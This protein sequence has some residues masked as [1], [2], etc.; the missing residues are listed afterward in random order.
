M[1]LKQEITQYVNAGDYQ[2]ILFCAQQSLAKTLRYVQM[3]IWGDDHFLPRW[4]AIEALGQLAAHFAGDNDEDFRNLIRRC[5][6]AMNDESGN[7]P[8]AAPEVMAVIIKA[9]PKQY[10][11]FIPM[12]MTNGLE[13]EICHKGTL[14]AMGYLGNSHYEALERFLPDILPFLDS[15][16]SEIRGCAVWALAQV[17]YQSAAAKI[18]ALKDDQGQCLLFHN[19]QLEKISVGKIAAEFGGLL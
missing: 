8:W 11:A 12:L 16:D 4:Y 6:W 7:V 19:G 1:T 15:K 13:N 17:G 14:W 5:L 9:K 3:N 10:D 2:K 18:A